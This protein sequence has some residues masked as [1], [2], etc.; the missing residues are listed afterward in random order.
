[1]KSGVIRTLSIVLI[2][3][4]SILA[5]ADA[6]SGNVKRCAALS[7]A[8]AHAEIKRPAAGP[9]I[10]IDDVDLFYRVYDAAHGQPSAD[11]LQHDYLDE[12]LEGLL[13]FAK[14][15]HVLGST[16]SQNLTKHP[17]MYSNAR[18]PPSAGLKAVGE[19]NPNGRPRT[20][21]MGVLRHSPL[22]FER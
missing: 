17:E 3:G 8:Q 12:G 18:T 5:L 21:L 6:N 10:S 9:R 2:V 16:I 22:N 4:G 1:M 14:L 15:R 11:D 20:G 19:T 13:E 7:Q